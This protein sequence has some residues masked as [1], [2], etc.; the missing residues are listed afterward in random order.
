MSCKILGLALLDVENIDIVRTENADS[1]FNA[2]LFIASLISF[3]YQMENKR[4]K[5]KKRK[6]SFKSYHRKR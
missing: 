3:H 1:P 5:R 6:A 2:L 4:K